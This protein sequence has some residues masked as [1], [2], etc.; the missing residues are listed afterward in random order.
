MKR[1]R[2]TEHRTVRVSVLKRKETVL[3]VD[4]D[5]SIRQ[6]MIWALED[7]GL[8]VIDAC[9]GKEALRR[10]KSAG[11]PIDLVLT[12]IVMPHLDGFTLFE[13]LRE[14]H[15]GARIIFLTGYADSSTLVR[16]GLWAAGYPFLLKPFTHQS[17][18][19]AV[20]Q[21]LATDVDDQGLGP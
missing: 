11:R 7:S 18:L 3:V 4:D 21:A 13:Q 5:P 14:S 20:E 10:A 1:H 2:S 15:P 8:R 17:L 6:L 19:G 12:D 9:N 16:G